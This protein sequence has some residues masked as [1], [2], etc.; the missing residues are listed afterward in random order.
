MPSSG[1]IGDYGSGMSSGSIGD[2]GYVERGYD[3]DYWLVV[4]DTTKALI[5]NILLIG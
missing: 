4:G 1:S 2:Y 3:V 5:F